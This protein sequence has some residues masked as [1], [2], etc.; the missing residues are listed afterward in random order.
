MKAYVTEPQA[1]GSIKSTEQPEP[2]LESGQAL[3]EVSHFSLNRGELQF[4]K[5]GPAGRAIGWDVAGKVI[6]S[7]AGGPEPGSAVV[8][9]SRASSGWAERVAVPLKDLAVL[10]A[11]V[12]PAQAACLPVA[13][14]TALYSL[15]RGQH[16]LGSPVLV[17][18]ATG[19][20]GGFAVALARLMGAEVVAQVR[21]DNQVGG[22]RELG[23]DRVVVDSDGKATAEAGPFRL[24]V[25]GL[26]NQL[27]A[28]VIH[29]LAPDGIAVIYGATDA[30]QLSIQPGFLL[31]TGTG[32]I[33]GFN[34]YRQSEVESVARGL[35]RLTKLLAQGKLPVALERQGSWAD[36]PQ[37]AQDLLDRK[38]SGKAVVE[39]SVG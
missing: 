33:E 2:T 17:T 23:A 36:A 1:T 14:L 21:R 6:Q 27:T 13:A 28:T 37:L 34:L 5:R 26:G 18:G 3:I 32:R 12:S 7:P 10:P 38:F 22:V 11:G 19:G 35:E 24:I 39:V 4:A 29:A 25:D 31:G 15:E 20:V 30:Q 16:L 8:A 9:F